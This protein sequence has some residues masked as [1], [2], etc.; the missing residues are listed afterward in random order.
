MICTSQGARIVS[1]HKKGTHGIGA[2]VHFLQLLR[3]STDNSGSSDHCRVCTIHCHDNCTPPLLSHL[4]W[5]L[6]GS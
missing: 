1:D 4:E 6:L 3:L 5:V 2:C